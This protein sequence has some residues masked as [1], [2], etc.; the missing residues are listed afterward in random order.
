MAGLT[1]DYCGEG[2]SGSKGM[3]LVYNN[4]INQFHAP[5][6]KKYDGEEHSDD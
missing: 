5:C 3:V 4:G 2:D 1:C 6:K